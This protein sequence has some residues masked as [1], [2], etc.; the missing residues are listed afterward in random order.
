MI[1]NTSLYVIDTM[2]IVNLKINEQTSVLAIFKVLISTSSFWEMTE[3]F[4]VFNSKD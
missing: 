3:M 4:T 1:G 2:I